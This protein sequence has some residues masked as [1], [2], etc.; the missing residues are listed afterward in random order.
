MCLE[1]WNGDTRNVPPINPHALAYEGVMCTVPP[2]KRGVAVGVDR[3][4][5]VSINQSAKSVLRGY[6]ND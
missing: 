2:A 4:F 3:R 5:Y 1:L 6:P